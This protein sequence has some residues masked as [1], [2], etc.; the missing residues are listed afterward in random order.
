MSA[1]WRTG[2]AGQVAFA[3]ITKDFEW[4]YHFGERAN[5][6]KVREFEK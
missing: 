2:S 3:Q 6:L 4:Q 1:S 5:F